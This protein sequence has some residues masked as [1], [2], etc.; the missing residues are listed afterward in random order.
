MASTAVTTIE[1]DVPDPTINSNGPSVRASV[2]G[3][4]VAAARLAV[5]DDAGAGDGWGDDDL[6]NLNENEEWGLYLKFTSGMVYP[7]YRIRY[8][9]DLKRHL[10]N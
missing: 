1:A 4:T 10:F 6:I 7:L 2:G 5:T 3:L 8:S 9:P